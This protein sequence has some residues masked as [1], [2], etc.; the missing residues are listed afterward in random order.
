MQARFR[1]H[2]SVPR[3][4]SPPGDYTV[5]V[6]YRA[7]RRPA[8]ST[9]YDPQVIL[10]KTT[11]L[12]R[13]ADLVRL[14]YSSWTGGTVPLQK[15]YRL[16]TKFSDFYATHLSADQRY[17]RKREGRGN[18]QLLLWRQYN[19]SPE[20][21]WFL[22][23]TAGEHPAHA[24]ERLRSA[25]VDRI[26]VTGYEL[27]QQTRPGQEKPAWTWR[28]SSSHYEA[29]RGS[30]VEAIR[31]HADMALAQAWQSLH[32]SPGFA[33]IR[34][35]V[36]KVAALCRAEWKRTRSGPFPAPSIR[37]PYVS[38]L[39]HETVP[40]RLLLAAN[41][42]QVSQMTAIGEG[43]TRATGSSNPPRLGLEPAKAPN[44]NSDASLTRS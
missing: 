5:H 8:V 41:A 42:K 38:R 40:L 3:A 24:H 31:R 4:F 2:P 7:T 12:Q 33:P 26:T 44:K 13:L 35:Q 9:K 32:R 28:M 14:G 18:A 11:L 6:F 15:A 21:H 43:G 1:E 23:V 30:V 27:V 39:R 19:D 22:L 37:V 29:W 20:I 36:R 16:A 10:H 34:R 17:R 25:R